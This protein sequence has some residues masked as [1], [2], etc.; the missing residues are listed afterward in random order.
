MRPD[1][2]LHSKQEP[3]RP[4]CPTLSQQPG[5]CT[6]RGKN[7]KDSSSGESQR[8][9]RNRTGPCFPIKARGCPNWSWPR[10]AAHLPGSILAI[11]AQRLPSTLWAS[12]M[13]RSSSSVQQDFFTS[14]LRWLCQRSRHCLPSRPFRC[15]AISVHCFVPY[16]LTSSMT[17]GESR[18][19]ASGTPR[20]QHPPRGC[21]P[22]SPDP[23]PRAG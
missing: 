18:C 19:E 15:L 7:L 10:Q 6:A 2:R 12:Q 3:P 9:Q 20:P 8:P 5:P 21:H 23:L 4:P 11:S 14:G 17:L 13:M 1:E 22:Q 16:F